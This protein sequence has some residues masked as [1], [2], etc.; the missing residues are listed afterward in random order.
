MLTQAFSVD[1]VQC[2]TKSVDSLFSR[3]C[4]DLRRCHVCTFWWKALKGV[5][6][7]TK[8]KMKTEVEE[9]HQ[10]TLWTWAKN[11][12]KVSQWDHTKTQTMNVLQTNTLIT[13]F[14]MLEN[15]LLT[16]YV[17]VRLVLA[18][19]HD[20]CSTVVHLWHILCKN[21]NAYIFDSLAPI[22][23]LTNCLSLEEIISRLPMC[24]E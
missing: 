3:L 11:Y 20:N 8:W 16:D 13:S 22:V 18:E 15:R 4:P 7:L 17:H 2:S 14:S 24:L 6:Y 9:H 23:T 1:E 12:R 5:L 21:V 19:L 10:Y